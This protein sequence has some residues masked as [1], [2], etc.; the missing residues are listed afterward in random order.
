MC[1][2]INDATAD[3]NKFLKSLHRKKSLKIIQGG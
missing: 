1:D 3:R 2:K